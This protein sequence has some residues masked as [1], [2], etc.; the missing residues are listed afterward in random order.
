MDVYSAVSL[1]VAV[2]LLKQVIFSLVISLLVLN[3]YS[4]KE[5]FHWRR[6]FHR[7]REIGVQ[8]NFIPGIEVQ[9]DPRQ[10]STARVRLNRQAGQNCGTA[11]HRLS[12]E[13]SLFKQQIIK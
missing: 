10:P 9:D 5:I 2:S 4:F 3:V 6:E 7:S 12:D 1:N 13:R 11:S 8:A